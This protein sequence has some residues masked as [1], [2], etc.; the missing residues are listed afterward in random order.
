MKL[1]LEKLLHSIT[2]HI[3]FINVPLITQI[4]IEITLNAI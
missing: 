4:G 1:A 3:K 2:V